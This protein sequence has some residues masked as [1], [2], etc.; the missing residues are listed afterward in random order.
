MR[1]LVLPF[2]LAV[3][4]SALADDEGTMTRMR[5]PALAGTGV[6][7]IVVGAGGLALG[8]YL[9]G[10]GTGTHD[11]DATSMGVGGAVALIGGAGAVAG[12]IAMLAVGAKSVPVTVALSGPR[13]STGVTIAFRF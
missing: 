12:G 11:G 7:T 2:I 10:V 1:W 3:P 6:A 4:T 5:S 13:A 9:V 8:T